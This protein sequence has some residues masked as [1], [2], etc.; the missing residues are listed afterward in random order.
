MKERW[1]TIK[2]YPLYQVSD[3]GN[4]RS[5]RHKDIKTNLNVYRPLRPNFKSNDRLEVTLCGGVNSRKYINVHRVVLTAFKGEPK[6]GQVCCH[7]NGIPWDNRLDNLRW[8]TMTSNHADKKK[9]GT[10]LEGA[11]HP[12]SKLKE[13]D[14]FW[15]RKLCEQKYDRQGIADKFGVS[16]CTISA[17]HTR[18]NWRHI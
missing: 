8:G 16:P 1:K 15:I 17:I 3:M 2:D 18:R 13:N 7:N 10:H 12:R 11:T 5:F 9:H 14:V 6:D 4:L